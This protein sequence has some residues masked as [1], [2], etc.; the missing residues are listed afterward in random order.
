MKLF[1]ACLASATML[2][3]CSSQLPNPTTAGSESLG[4][5]P[6]PSGTLSGEVMIVRWH[7][8]GAALPSDPSKPCQTKEPL[9]YTFAVAT[10]LDQY[11]DQVELETYVTS[12]ATGHYSV[13]IP[14]GTYTLV[15]KYTITKAFAD[16]DGLSNEVV[17]PFRVAAG[18]SL[19][20]DFTVVPPPPPISIGVGN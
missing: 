18:E 20:Q 5:A 17:A 14:P 9:S 16:A 6:Q 8:G 11:G 10:A 19:S 2:G 12:D 1:L 13:S 15:R 4:A 3:A 7:C